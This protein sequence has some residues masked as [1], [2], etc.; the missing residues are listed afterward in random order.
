MKKIKVLFGITLLLVLFFLLHFASFIFMADY[1]Y[2]LAKA[3]EEQ[4]VFGKYNFIISLI[5]TIGI[6]IGL[7]I[8]LKCLY[9]I[10]KEGFFTVTSKKLMYWAGLVFFISGITMCGFDILKFSRGGGEEATMI[11][12]I[13]LD[14]MF[15]LFG[16]VVL[17]IAD[18]AQ[19]GFQLKSENDLTI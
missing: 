17:I 5:Q 16:F 6:F 2:E 10:I 1:Y 3:T 7:L 18:M 9:S 4:L 11:V 15:A 19:T 8:S 12:I 13:M 14:F